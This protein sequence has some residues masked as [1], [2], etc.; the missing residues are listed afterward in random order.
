MRKPSVRT[1]PRVLVAD[2]DPDA[3]AIYSTYLR[4]KGCRVF[5]ASDGALA[6]TRALRVLPAVI[7]LDLA[8]PRMDGWLVARRLK[9]NRSTSAIPIIALSAVQTSRDSARDAGCDAFLAK[10]C[11]PELLWCE[12]RVVLHGDAAGTEAEAGSV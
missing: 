5:T 3:R 9:A 8:M 7:V 6:V 12:I 4:A 1:G 2:D 11:L 10:P